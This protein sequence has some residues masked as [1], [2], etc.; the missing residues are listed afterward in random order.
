[1]KHCGTQRIETDMS[2]LIQHEYDH[3]DGI[4]VSLEELISQTI[5]ACFFR[6]ILIIPKTRQYNHNS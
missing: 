1:M 2:E 3:L 5:R 4:L 6:D